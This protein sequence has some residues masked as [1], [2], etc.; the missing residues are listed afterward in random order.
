MAGATAPGNTPGNALLSGAVVLT[1]RAWGHE[2]GNDITAE[3]LNPGV[4]SSPLSV[5][6]SGN[7]ITVRLATNATGG[8]SSTGSQVVAAI[9]ADPAAAQLVR[10]SAFTR[11]INA[12]QV[13]T[14]I[15]QPRS[16]CIGN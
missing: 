3:F 8:L 12:S 4:A 1:S 9:N 10:A 16:R 14:G 5:A 11:N 2:G 6:V 7:D 13:G 15:V